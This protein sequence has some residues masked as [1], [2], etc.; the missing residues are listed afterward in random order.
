MPAIATVVSDA[1]D[2]S[3]VACPL[4]NSQQENYRPAGVKNRNV[5]ETVCLRRRRAKKVARR[6]NVWE[7]DALNV[8]L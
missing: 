2:Y 5:M 6:G 8:A 4:K 1:L 7:G 3:P